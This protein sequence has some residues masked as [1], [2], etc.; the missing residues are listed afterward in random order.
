[1]SLA[2]VC[3]TPTSPERGADMRKTLILLADWSV[4]KATLPEEIVPGDIVPEDIVGVWDTTWTSSARRGET[5]RSRRGILLASTAANAGKG[6]MRGTSET[7]SISSPLPGGSRRSGLPEVVRSAISVPPDNA[8]TGARTGGA[9][10]CG[11]G[12]PIFNGRV[13]GGGFAPGAE[14][15]PIPWE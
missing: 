6:A 4:S 11:G 2:G 10:A 13:G 8:R 7:G 9:L 1:M 12:L 14:G 3:N 15:T 5:S